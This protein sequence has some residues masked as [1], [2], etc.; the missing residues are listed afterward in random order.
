MPDDKSIGRYDSFYN[1]K[2]ADGELKQ[3]LNN[4]PRPW[5]RMLIDALRAE[6][7]EGSALLDIGGGV[8]VIQHELLAAGV[9]TAWSVD[10]SAAYLETSRRESERRGFAG[11]VTYVHGDFVE[12]AASV[13]QAD[14]VT[15]ER[16]VNTYLDWEPLVRLSAERA[17][18]LY[19]LV[20]PRDT[21]PVKMVV[22]VMNLRPGAVRALVHPA[23][24]IDR[25]VRA[26][27]FDACFSGTAGPWQ[28]ALYRRG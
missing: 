5:T 1:Q 24:E 14:I 13:P 7:I 25:V 28:V 6:G 26:A 9:A 11:R 10:A 2:Y 12:V 20:Y 22:F 21:L 15:L 23:R 8:G 27:G 17:R 4:G 3:Y 16:V 19:A 18:R